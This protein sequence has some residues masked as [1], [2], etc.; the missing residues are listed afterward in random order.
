MGFG[1]DAPGD[2]MVVSRSLDQA[3]FLVLFTLVFLG[4]LLISPWGFD[5]AILIKESFLLFTSG[6]LVLLLFLKMTAGRR[7]SFKATPLGRPILLLLAFVLLSLFQTVNL[8]AALYRLALFLAGVS[9]FYV[10]TYSRLDREQITALAKAAVASASIA[11]AYAF[12]QYLQLDPIFPPTVGLSSTLGN[13]NFLAEYLIVALPLSLGLALSSPLPVGEGRGEGGMG[14]TRFYA[15]AALLLFAGLL[16]SKARGA[17]LGFFFSLALFT[18]LLRRQRMGPFKAEVRRL[19]PFAALAL[20][21]AVLFGGAFFSSFAGPGGLRGILE[22]YASSRAIYFKWRLVF[23]R[24]SLRMALDDPLFGVG[25]GNF[26]SVYP[27]Y[28]SMPET[29]DPKHFVL[30]HAHNDYLELWAELGLGGLLAFLWLLW[31]FFKKMLHPQGGSLLAVAYTASVGA[32]AVNSLFAFGLYNPVP[33]AAFWLSMALALRLQAE[34]PM[35]EESA[36]RHPPSAI[37]K[38]PPLWAFLLAIP[39][40]VGLLYASLRPLVADAYLSRGYELFAKGQVDDA[41]PVLQ[42]AASLSPARLEAQVYL[43]EAYF[44]ARRHREAMAVLDR[45]LKHDPYNFQ[46]H[47]LLGLNAEQVGDEEAALKAYE[48]ARRIYPL[49]SRPLL[50]IGMIRERRG[51][52]QGAIAAYREAIRLN[53][54]FAEASNNLA[55]LL[56]N[57]GRLD[58]AIQVWE[59]GARGSPE[60]LVIAQNLA[61]AYWKKG[62]RQRALLWVGR[63]ERLRVKGRR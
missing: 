35:G 25:I 50:R 33:F 3:I 46:V 55:I 2:L 26:E 29:L 34:T 12:A 17:S 36:I 1:D 15:F 10:A 22:R 56:S 57:Q 31:A 45:Y 30:D 44:K 37:H 28:R 21:I 19:F 53:P 48:E 9:L 18:F 60:D 61:L 62:D 16:L 47:Y 38:R 41:I 58:E 32:L 23:Y 63:V 20:V 43:A 39:A 6:L 49:Y 24:D 5:H 4:P 52:L 7:F 54:S 51:D 11:T 59:E 14:G 40:L 8:P 13:P 42:K 27:L